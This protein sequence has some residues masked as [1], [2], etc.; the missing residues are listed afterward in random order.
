MLYSSGTTGRPKGVR[1][2]LPGTSFGEPSSAPV[3]IAQGIAASGIGPG[4]RLPLARA[5]VPRRAA[6]VLDVGASHSAAPSS[7]WSASTRRCAW[8][9]SNGIAS[10]TPSSCRRCSSACC[11]CPRTSAPRYDVSS[12]QVVMHAAAPCP[13]AIKRQMIDWWGP[14]IHEYYSG[15]EDIGGTFITADEWLAHPG[16]SDGPA[17]SATSS[18][19]MATSYRPARP[20]AVY[21][22]G[23]RPFEYHNDAEKTG[24]DHQRPGLADARRHRLPRRGRLPLPHRPPGAHDHLGRRE[25]L[26]AGGGERARRPPGGRRRRR[27]RRPRRG[28]GRGGEGGRPARRR[29]RR[30]TE[31]LEAELLALCRSAARH[32]QVPEVR[33]LR[34]RSSR[35]TTTA[36]S[37]SDSSASAT[38]RAT[39]PVSSDQPGHR[40]HRTLK[41]A[42][43][44]VAGGLVAG[45]SHPTWSGAG[46]SGEP[47]RPRAGSASRSPRRRPRSSRPTT[48][49]TCTSSSAAAVLP[50]SSST[51][52]RS[53]IAPGTTSSST[54]PRTSESSPSTSG[55]TVDRRR[56][57]TRSA[58]GASPPT[59][60]PCWNRWTSAGR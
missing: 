18:I 22:A 56:V 60:R 13:V 51:A 42:G 54:S 41:I 6:R 34:R 40:A 35:E 2:P 23:G 9:S 3:Q 45:G 20:G 25:H 39:T 11:A 27:D 30:R 4:V 12:L 49:Q 15:T 52:S 14:I 38:G 36:S 16:R 47:S 19:P 50:C 24:V 29:R 21:F 59:S 8:S 37:T 46:T 55:A 53:T 10:P 26:S 48:A 33:R 32:L 17:R 44:L 43:G 31:R 28:D 7:S 57:A 5:A 58:P 1:K